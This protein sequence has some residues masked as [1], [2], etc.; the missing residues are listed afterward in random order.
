MAASET[1]KTI[2]GLPS[3]GSW[4]IFNKLQTGYYRVNYDTNNWKLIVSQLK[5]KHDVIST[6]N[7]ATLIDDAL[8]FAR[9]GRLSYDI[10]MDVNSYLSQETEYVP[11]Y[12]ALN[13]LGYIK[14]MLSRTEAYGAFKVR[15][16]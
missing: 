5:R 7:R 10:A 6:I 3:T 8:D 4:V 13:N 2:T 9:A 14:N 12:S 11:W 15:V 16:I 1:T